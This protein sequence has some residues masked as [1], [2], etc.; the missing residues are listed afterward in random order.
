MRIDGY[1]LN[2]VPSKATE[3]PAGVTPSDAKPA[4]A[5]PGADAAGDFVRS[6]ELTRLIDLVRQQPDVREDV[7]AAVR[8]RLAAGAYDTPEAAD[9]T[10][11]A[12]L[13]ADQ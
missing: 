2:G 9:Q 6:A 1:G 10:A 3:K 12:I 11:R 8:Q 5:A 4:A 7:L 13:G